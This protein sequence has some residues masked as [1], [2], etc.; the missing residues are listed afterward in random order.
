MIME[1]RNLPRDVT[2]TY[3]RKRTAHREERSET[4]AGTLACVYVEQSLVWQRTHLA[5][6]MRQGRGE[7]EAA[8]CFEI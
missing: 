3:V 5:E 8:L 4:K 2:N 7:E 6:T 1:H